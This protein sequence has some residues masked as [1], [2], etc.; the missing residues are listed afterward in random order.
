MA[1]TLQK[2]S[3]LPIIPFDP[4]NAYNIEFIY[5]DN[6]SVKNRAV[7]TDNE[8]GSIVYDS[9]QS[10][11]RL[12][13]TLPAN[14]LIAGKQYLVQIQVFDI[15]NNSSNLSDPV[16]FLCLTTPNFNFTNLVN[17]T[18]FKQ[19]NITLDLEYSQTEGE[20][21]KNYQF[22]RYNASRVQLDSSE[23]MYNKD[24]LTYTFYGLENNS[25]YY[26]RAIG[27][28]Q[29]GISLDTGYFEI[30]VHL[31][32]APVNVAVQLEND[33]SN[34]VIRVSLNIKDVQYI[35]TGDKDYI[36]ENGMVTLNSTTLTYNDGFTVGSGD[37]FS[38]FCQVAKV[39]IGTFFS[40][41]NGLI[42]LT[43]LKICDSYYCA[44]TIQGNNFAQYVKLENALV[45]DDGQLLMDSTRDYVTFIIRRRSDL[46]G[47]EM[48]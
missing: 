3:I 23:V 8:T 14:T 17:G 38:M 1:V 7:I 40:M 29:N 2:P 25:T 44:L 19:A 46:Y 41:E 18:V 4:S 21:L 12:F 43:I 27:E 32:V 10:T 13:H 47:L 35:L 45:T 33:Y 9:S 26:L 30:N 31:T 28:T 6:Q 37:D 48:E 5:S 20:Q 34:G 36:F 16:L 39:T 22:I 42:Q 24:T 11:M 15:D